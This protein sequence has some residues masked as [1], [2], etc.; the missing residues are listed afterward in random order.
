M[1]LLILR[2]R[3]RRK[4]SRGRIEQSR[5]EHEDRSEET[6]FTVEAIRPCWKGTQS[7][8]ALYV[9]AAKRFGHQALEFQEQ[10][11]QWAKSTP[12]APLFKSQHDLIRRWFDGSV[13]IARALWQLE[14]EKIGTEK[15]MHETERR[16]GIQNTL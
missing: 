16:Y 11:S 5:T 2:N 3:Q 7:L 15:A 4:I 14:A 6:W 8:V 13:N 12:W 10:A 9:D 1:K